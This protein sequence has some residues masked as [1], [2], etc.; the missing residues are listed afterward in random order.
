M[1]EEIQSPQHDIQT[2]ERCS[3]EPGE[4]NASHQPRWQQQEEMLKNGDKKFSTASEVP[5]RRRNF[6]SVFGKRLRLF[7]RPWKWRRK[8]RRSKEN[9]TGPSLK[10][11]NRGSPK[12]TTR[13]TRGKRRKRGM[14][15]I[16]SDDGG[17]WGRGSR[18]DRR[19]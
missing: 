12:S 16:R 9:T 15:R 19:R 17:A 2:R 6:A 4:L 11:K 13:S 18:T 5:T 3:S 14:S 8:G 1:G 10:T 7:F